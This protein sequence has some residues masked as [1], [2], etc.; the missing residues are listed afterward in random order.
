MMNELSDSTKVF[1]ST[2]A[3]SPGYTLSGHRGD[4]SA[5]R[6]RVARQGCRGHGCS[7]NRRDVSQQG[8]VG[9]I[10]REAAEAG[11]DRRRL[12][13]PLFVRD[14]VYPIL[15]PQE[16]IDTGLPCLHTRRARLLP[17]MRK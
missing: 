12:S 17:R 14:G 13:Q 1:M 7:A 4:G 3:V 6:T 8:S 11:S 5:R 16:R 10:S 9:L 2:S 15:H